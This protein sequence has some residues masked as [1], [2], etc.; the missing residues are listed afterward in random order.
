MA[1][2]DDLQFESHP[3]GNGKWARLFLDNGYGISVVSGPYFYCIEGKSFEV[4][5]LKNGQ[6][7]YD[8]PL[9]DDVLGYQTQEDINNIIKE[10]ES[11]AQ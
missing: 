4:A 8:T 6:I 11:Y 1:T 9:T 10:L 2:F 5:I 3:L 7:T